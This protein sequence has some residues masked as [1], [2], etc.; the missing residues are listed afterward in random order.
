MV[1]NEKHLDALDQKFTLELRRGIL[2][3]A[4][5]GAVRSPTYGYSLKQRLTERQLEI[6]QGTLY[7]LLRRLESEGLLTSDWVVD[8]SRPRKYY[9][10]SPDGRTVLKGLEAKWKHLVGV[11]EALL[12]EASSEGTED[13]ARG[14]ET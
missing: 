13:S 3:L 8:G 14:E 12:D 6:D 7:P 11:V 2:T 10:L 4:V 9:R 1:L 5:L